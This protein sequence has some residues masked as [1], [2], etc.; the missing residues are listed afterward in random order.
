MGHLHYLAIIFQ[1][2]I[3]HFQHGIAKSQFVHEG[4][5]FIQLLMS[6]TVWKSLMYLDVSILICLFSNSSLFSQLLPVLHRDLPHL[7]HHVSCH[8]DRHGLEGSG[9]DRLHVCPQLQPDRVKFALG[10]T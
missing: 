8:L 4:P 7:L 3:H 9:L 1:Y 2:L 6:G 5:P 10:R